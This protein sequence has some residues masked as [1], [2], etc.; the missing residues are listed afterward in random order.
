MSALIAALALLQ[1]PVFK[2]RWFYVQ[3]NLAVTANAD[4]LV[5]VMER[6]K[7]AGYN[8]FVI[9]DTKFS[10][11]DRVTDTYI[12]NATRI[13]DLAKE[14]GL[15][16][17]PVVAD[18]GYA[19]ALLSH[20]VNLIEG[21]QVKRA[22]FV[23]KNGFLSPV[24]EDSFANADLEQANGNKLAGISYQDGVGVSSFVDTSVVHGGRQSLRFENFRGENQAGNCRVMHPLAV[25]PYQQYRVR[26]WLKTEGVGGGGELRCFAMNAAGK[27][28][29]FQDVGAKPTQ[30]WTQ[31]TIV[32]NSQ[33]NNA[34]T[35]Y[36][37]LWGGKDGRF[38]L[39]DFSIEEAGLL[40]VLKRPGTPVTIE[41]EGAKVN[42]EL[43]PTD[44]V[45][46]N[47]GQKP[48]PGEYTF[49]HALPRISAKGLAEGTKLFI[50]YTHAISTETGKTVICPSEPGSLA[51]LDDVF[52]RVAALWKPAGLMLGHDEI[53]VAN[54]CPLC[55][56]RGLNPG[57]N[58]AE[59]LRRNDALRA[60]YAP[61]GPTYIWSDM[62]DP[63]HNA[64]D[65]Y[66]LSNGTW[67]ESWAGINSKMVVL[68]WNSFAAAESLKFFAGKGCKQILAG[69]YDS[70]VENIKKWKQTAAGVPGVEG[71]M[72]T[73][74]R[75]DYSQLE[76]FAKVAWGQ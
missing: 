66:Y 7:K 15:T 33:D 8:G 52:K 54:Q 41:F 39:D 5:S 45:D 57:Q 47:L 23:V 70:P 2:Q 56:S 35:L 55:V 74:W 36:T 29:S 44:I 75:G 27:V 6:A 3:T 48:W 10:F 26:F 24:Q 20:D 51:V 30:D 38:W 34:V 16:V 50:S 37:G 42:S 40:N 68:N 73:T 69:F 64:K 22:P 21:Q 25:R 43:R 53:R 46:P 58:Y 61:T 17:T 59:D 67:K 28:L 72:Y 4:S 12:K 31:H 63:G 32:F 13:R 18:V 1:T 9:T 60:K 19:G 11:L 65:V 49:D 62:F 71:V 14:L 76:A